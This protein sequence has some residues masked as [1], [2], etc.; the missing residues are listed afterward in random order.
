[1]K[2]YL[3]SW[4][5]ES[6]PLMTTSG[7]YTI[8]YYARVVGEWI[9]LPEGTGGRN[10]IWSSSYEE[11]VGEMWS[12]L[13]DR[14]KNLIAAYIEDDILDDTSDCAPIRDELRDTLDEYFCG[15]SPESVP[16]AVRRF[17]KSI[18]NCK[19]FLHERFDGNLRGCIMFL[20]R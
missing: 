9:A 7:G 4:K 15:I 8:P 3:K 17:V 20:R 13:T 16:L 18:D 1:M 10:V 12:L 2:N 19:D 14:D 6:R 5:A 11:A